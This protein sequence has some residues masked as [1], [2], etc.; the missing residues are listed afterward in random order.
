MMVFL[1]LVTG[2]MIGLLLI[3]CW[4]MIL[5]R[6]PRR[7]PHEVETNGDGNDARPVGHAP[8]DR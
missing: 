8:P 4:V 5:D 2:A 1:G 6:P 3:S 7:G